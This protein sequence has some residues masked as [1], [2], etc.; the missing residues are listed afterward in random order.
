MENAKFP[1][2]FWPLPFWCVLRGIR[3]LLT[4]CNHIEHKIWHLVVRFYTLQA[5]GHMSLWHLCSESE[6]KSGSLTHCLSDKVT[7]WAVLDIYNSLAKL[8]LNYQ[9]EIVEFE[10]CRISSGESKNVICAGGTGKGV[11]FVSTPFHLIL[12]CLLLRLFL[13]DPFWKLLISAL[14]GQ[15]AE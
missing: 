5:T 6:F 8:I 15:T 1:Y 12:K 11:C 14:N 10:D 2:F 7:N 4:Q 13:A 3:F 9:V